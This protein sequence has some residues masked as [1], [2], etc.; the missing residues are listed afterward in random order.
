M[1]NSL[2]RM[3]WLAGTVTSLL[4]VLLPSFGIIF[5]CFIVSLPIV[6]FG[7]VSK[8]QRKVSFFELAVYFTN[9]LFI[10]VVLFSVVDSDPQ[11]PIAIVLSGLLSGAIVMSLS[12]FYWLTRTAGKREEDVANLAE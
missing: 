4:F 11:S 1:L 12:F 7:F 3:L 10:C 6:V 9:F 8:K 2:S 5:V